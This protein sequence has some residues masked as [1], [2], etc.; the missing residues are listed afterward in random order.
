MGD[1]ER[2]FDYFSK[3][4]SECMI[5]G[6]RIADFVLFEFCLELDGFSLM[7]LVRKL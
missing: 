4:W 7:L 3:K 1:L 2:F 6:V 5:F